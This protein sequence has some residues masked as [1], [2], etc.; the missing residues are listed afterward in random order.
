MFPKQG[1]IV[2][3]DAEPHS[4]NEI[5]GHD[6]SQGNIRRPFLVLSREGFNKATGTFYGMAI[7]HVHR[8]AYNR[9]AIVD[10]ATKINGDLLL[11]KVPQYSF[12]SR[13]SKVIGHIADKSILDQA[14][15]IFLQAF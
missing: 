9:L 2:M 4:G 14:L 7:T 6:P 3:C 5:G 8:D 15:R 1:D 11:N 13:N 12:K 10:F